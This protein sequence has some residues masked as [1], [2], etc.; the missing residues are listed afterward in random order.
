VS[1]LPA[2]LS[3]AWEPFVLVIGLLLIG[4]VAAKDGLFVAA[5]AKL[6]GLRGGPRTLFVAMMLLVAMVTAVLNLDTAVVFLTPVLLHTARARRV[7]EAP[8][9][10]GAIFMSNSASLLFFGSNL[11]NILVFSHA[12][13]TGAHFAS[14]MAPAWLTSVVLTIAVV[15]VV[16]H[17]HLRGTASLEV[18]VAPRF[19]VGPG[20]AGVVGATLAML[21]MSQ[22]A[23]AV[24]AVAL[25]VISYDVA[26][27]HRLALT[28]LIRSANLPVVA[29]LFVLAV[30]VSVVSRQ[31]HLSE[32]LLAAASPWRTALVGTVAANVVNNLPAAV[33]LSST[34]PAHPYHLLLG[35]NLGP[36]L[37]VTGALSSVLWLRVA[38][39]EGAT[40]SV[41]TFTKV[42]AVVTIVTIGVAC[43]VL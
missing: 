3:Q 28:P 23:L 6:A 26:V 19:I 18:A 11:T 25:S 9:L 10:Y 27:R 40:P 7:P 38:R 13:V 14:V 2:A 32:H 20:V 4:H 39:R 29:G 35:L 42:G 43:L 17:R 24:L 15:G 41:V 37:S 1:H 8:F 16:H 33:L 30:S 34:L 12:G 5:G 22:P 21:T 36:N 31:W